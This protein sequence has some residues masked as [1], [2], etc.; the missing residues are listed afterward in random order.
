MRDTRGRYPCVVGNR[1]DILATVHL[2][3]NVRTGIPILKIKAS[4]YGLL[5]FRFVYRGYFKAVRN[6]NLNISIP[7]GIFFH[8]LF[9]IKTCK[10]LFSCRLPKSC[11][12][13]KYKCHREECQNF[14]GMVELY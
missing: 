6:K 4:T 12:F 10:F 1:D 7:K 13:Q 14:E 2:L 5:H 9:I 3:K 11:S 8:Y